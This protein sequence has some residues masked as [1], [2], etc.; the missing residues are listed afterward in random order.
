[1]QIMIGCGPFTPTDSLSYESLKDLLDL[2]RETDP[3]P[4]SYLGH[5]SINSTKLSFQVKSIM[6]ASK[7][8]TLSLQITKHCSLIL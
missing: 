5:S 2:V 1:M 6:R 8:L 3:M 4:Y 7:Q